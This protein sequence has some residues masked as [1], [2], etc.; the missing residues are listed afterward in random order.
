MQSHERALYQF[1]ALQGRIRYQQALRV[2][3][4]AQQVN[5]LFTEAPAYGL[6]MIFARVVTN[7][8]MELVYEFD[9]K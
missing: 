4:D 5:N 3:F 2:I 7:S 6:T 8:R 1:A 9:I